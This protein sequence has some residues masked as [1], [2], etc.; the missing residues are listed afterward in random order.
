MAQ[1]R[2]VKFI[3]TSSGIQHNIDELLVGILKQVVNSIYEQKRQKIN[4]QTK[5]KKNSFTDKLEGSQR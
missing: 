5:P 1:S 2:D 4:E 3:E